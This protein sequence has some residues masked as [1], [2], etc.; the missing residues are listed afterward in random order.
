[1]I[2]LWLREKSDI[3]IHVKPNLPPTHAADNIQLEEKDRDTPVVVSFEPE[4]LDLEQ[5]VLV[6]FDGSLI[7][8]NSTMAKELK[9]AS[10]KDMSQAEKALKGFY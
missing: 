1:L 7:N 4:G 10:S 9:L 5:G 8:I 6:I 3:S 2:V